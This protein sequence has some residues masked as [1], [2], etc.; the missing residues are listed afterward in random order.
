M[1]EFEWLVAMAIQT[2]PEVE[3]SDTETV[4]VQW[5]RSDIKT[6]NDLNG[7]YSAWKT[8]I[9]KKET[10]DETQHLPRT[11][12]QAVGLGI[13]KTRHISVRSKRN[14]ATLG[15]GFKMDVDNKT[16]I[17]NGERSTTDALEEA[18]EGEQLEV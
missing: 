1:P 14:I 2:V 12:I 17:W 16:L 7:R 8:K 4:E 13:I 3:R 10:V 5:Y 18:E 11:C 6:I 9:S 15:V